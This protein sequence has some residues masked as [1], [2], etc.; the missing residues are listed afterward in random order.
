MAAVFESLADYNMHIRSRDPRSPG[1][2]GQLYPYGY[3]VRVH[4]YHRLRERFTTIFTSNRIK[5]WPLV[6]AV[7]DLPFQA[8]AWPAARPIDVNARRRTL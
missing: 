5:T 8:S 2:A 1:G 7:L 3:N 6:V 4:G